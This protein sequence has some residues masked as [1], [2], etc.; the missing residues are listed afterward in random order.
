VRL[1]A[2]AAL[3]AILAL[4]SAFARA[5]QPPVAGGQVPSILALALGEPGPFERI[6][7]TSQSARFATTIRVE[8]TATDSP[9]KLSLADG[10]LLRIWRA[11][12]SGAPARIRLTETVSS[13]RALRARGKLLLVTLTAGGP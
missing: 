1:G 10:P 7:G 5:Q 11:P 4:S 8:A 2:L 13:A 12:I 3:T 6:G 9:A